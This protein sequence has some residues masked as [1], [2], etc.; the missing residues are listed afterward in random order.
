MRVVYIAHPVAPPCRC[1]YLG[2]HEGIAALVVACN[3]DRARRWLSWAI[4]TYPD[5]AFAMPWLPYVDVLPDQG[6]SRAR[7]LRD[8]VAMALRCDEIWLVGGRVSRGMAQE[9]DAMAAAGKGVVDLTDL[10]PEPPGAGR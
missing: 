8:D 5:V 9:R 6:D 4:R 1:D 2:T 3:C 7:G 10:G